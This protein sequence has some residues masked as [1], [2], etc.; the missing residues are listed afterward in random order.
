MLPCHV[1][2]CLKINTKLILHR[3]HRTHLFILDL[4]ASSI[5][6]QYFYG[7]FMFSSM[8][9]DVSSNQYTITIILYSKNF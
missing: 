1:T 6:Y 5:L 9:C 2:Q 4:S 8:S 3:P 7:K